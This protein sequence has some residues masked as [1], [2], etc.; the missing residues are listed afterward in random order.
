MLRGRLP[1]L[2]L[3]VAVSH[4]SASTSHKSGFT[5]T[6]DGDYFIGTILGLLLIHK[7]EIFVVWDYC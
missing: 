2:S 4:V 3:P 1:Q 5:S 7:N 6:Q